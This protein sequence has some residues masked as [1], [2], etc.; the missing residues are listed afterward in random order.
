META[1]IVDDLLV[2][3]KYQVE[4]SP[5]SCFIVFSSRE[6]HVEVVIDCIET[7]F[8]KIGKYQVVRLDQ[9]L[10]SGDS[11]YTELTDL[12]ATCCFAIIIL[13]GFRPNVLFEYGVLKG[14]GKPC[15]VLLEENA[16]V[17]VKGYFAN[18]DEVP[19]SAPTIDI[20]KHFSDVKD[21]FYV[22][23]NRNKPKQ[24]RATLKAE[25]SKLKKRIEEEF[26]NILFPHWDIIEKEITLY[27][28]TIV[29]VF[30]KPIDSLGKDDVVS[31]DTARSHVERIA[32][33]NG[34][35]LPYR[36]F[37]TIAHSYDKAGDPQKAIAFIDSS[38][39]GVAG[40][41]P[42]LSDKAF[43]LQKSGNS[44]GALEAL[45]AGIKLRPTAESLWHNKAIILDM[46][47]KK[48]EAEHCFRKA[49]ALDSGCSLVHY[50]YG[51]LLYQKND[52][53]LAIEE[54][55]KAIEKQPDNPKYLLWKARSLDSNGSRD[56]ARRIIDGLVSS[57]PTDADVW[58]VLGRMEEDDTK[59]L[60]FF[61]KAIQLNPNH[62]G[63]LCSSAAMLSNQGS[64]DEAIEIFS[65]MQNFCPRHEICQTLITNICTTLSRLERF[66][67]GIQICDKILEKQPNHHGALHGKAIC[68]TYKGEYSLA[69]EIF[70][71]LLKKSPKE[72]DL[73]YDQ[74]CA[75][76]LAKKSRE[77]VRSLQKTFALDPK[78]KTTVLNDADFDPIR[79]TKV[80]R[81]ALVTQ[82]KTVQK[83][84]KKATSSA[85]MSKD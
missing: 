25:Y 84:A 36:Y 3:L 1:K 73:W 34:I 80:F 60:E 81:E 35:S 65:N 18:Q 37:S 40:D 28:K 31:V 51:I 76:A 69:F 10:K 55:N 85:R 14:L 53:K 82:A 29:D 7:V 45:D 56:E 77:A 47:D 74:A 43:I 13:D 2:T 78:Y 46:L 79:R 66:E 5:R 59:A 72:A 22:R 75:Y 17:D 39:K 70:S 57:E 26:F 44:N 15:I 68:L 24:I 62:G 48:E 42:I 52:F 67:D 50:H 38:L 8:E 32:I 33:E 21:R 9:H 27:L 4:E 23:Y 30:N 61:Q 71:H 49:V 19:V 63:A 64:F 58:F 83:R 6:E 41:V 20:D 12:L 54:F 16:T 11:Q